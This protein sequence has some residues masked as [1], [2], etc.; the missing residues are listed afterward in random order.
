[1]KLEGL[2][3][4]LTRTYSYVYGITLLRCSAIWILTLRVAIKF[5]ISTASST[6]RPKSYTIERQVIVEHS[7]HGFD[8][9]CE[10]YAHENLRDYVRTNLRM[11][12]VNFSVPNLQK[13][14][15]M[16]TWCYTVG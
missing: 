8:P 13:N 3:T 9:N 11:N 1:M 7:F 2:E 5:L 15:T 10:I 6:I 4:R 14:C 12:H 16:E